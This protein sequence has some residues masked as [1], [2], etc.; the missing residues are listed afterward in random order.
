MLLMGGCFSIFANSGEVVPSDAPKLEGLTDHPD[1]QSSKNY[2]SNEGKR[3]Q[4]CKVFP[5]FILFYVEGGGP[6]IA[7]VRVRNRQNLSPQED[8]CANTSLSQSKLLKMPAGGWGEVIGAISSYLFLWDP[9]PQGRSYLL[10]IVDTLS[11]KV[12]FET[13]YNPS[14]K[15]KVAEADKEISLHYFS[16]LELK[17]NLYVQEKACWDQMLKTLQIPS[18][19]KL[20]SPNCTK[21]YREALQKYKMKASDLSKGYGVEAVSVPVRVADLRKPKVEYEGG[22]ATCDLSP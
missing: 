5:K 14:R 11:G 10:Y 20:E 2:P 9:E 12:V 16:S 19:L 1:S 15:F 8:L 18:S 3:N 13:R 21:A 4:V 17:C 6:G 22:Q 7:D